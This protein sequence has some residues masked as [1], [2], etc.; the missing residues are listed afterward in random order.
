M[1]GMLC[2]YVF[3]LALSASLAHASTISGQ[4]VQFVVSSSKGSL[5]QA[6][7]KSNKMILHHHLIFKAQ[8]IP[9]MYIKAKLTIPT[10]Y[11]TSC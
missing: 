6:A 3:A 5:R 9:L 7:T 11:W 1:D 2:V 4:V 10:T 8:S